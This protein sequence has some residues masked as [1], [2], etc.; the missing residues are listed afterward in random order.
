M[1]EKKL[2]RRPGGGLS[3]HPV[4]LPSTLS[5][6][7]TEPTGGQY[8]LSKRPGPA[9]EPRD[10][11]SPPMTDTQ[12]RERMNSSTQSLDRIYAGPLAFAGGAA[13]SARLGPAAFSLAMS[14]QK[15]WG[16]LKA[17]LR[18]WG[19]S[20]LPA[21]SAPNPSNQPSASA[22]GSNPPPAPPT[23]Q[24]RKP[25]LSSEDILNHAR[26][27]RDAYPDFYERFERFIE[28]QHRNDHLA[29][30]ETMDA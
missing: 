7:T 19:A 2:M 1:K 27:H 20:M 21:S 14:W 29:G 24:P 5:A 23:K 8:D 10:R 16:K 13:L 25:Q 22:P 18:K 3:S 17:Q 26:S 30:R 9:F 15:S 28:R 12:L 4:S 6:R 11:L